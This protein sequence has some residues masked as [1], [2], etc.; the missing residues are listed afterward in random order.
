M[1]ID[2]M[3]LETVNYFP[4]LRGKIT[5]DERSVTDIKSRIA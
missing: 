4:N 5:S 1:V 2:Y 3:R